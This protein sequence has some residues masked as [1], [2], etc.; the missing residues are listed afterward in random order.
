M[1]DYVKPMVIPESGCGEGVYMASGGSNCLTITANIEAT[2][3]MGYENYSIRLTGNHTGDHYSY[4]QRA[5]I[6]FNKTVGFVQQMGGGTC[7]GSSS[8]TTLVIEWDLSAYGIGP[9]EQHGYGYLQ[10]TAD[11]GLEV[12]SVV[13]ED[14]SSGSVRS[15]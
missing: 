12:L 2:P 5:T 11:P 1:K 13:A 3:D 9:G 8:G 10:V 15:V 14:L 4:R 7:V 6:T